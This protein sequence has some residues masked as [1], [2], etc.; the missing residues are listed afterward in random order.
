M[1]VVAA[2]SGNTT[3]MTTAMTER[4]ATDGMKTK[5]KKLTENLGAAVII[6]AKP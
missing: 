1:S 4:T 5:L 2:V 6:Y 3:T